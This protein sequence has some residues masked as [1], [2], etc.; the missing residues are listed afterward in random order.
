[1][2]K[3]TT[4]LVAIAKPLF[5]FI[6]VLLSLVFAKGTRKQSFFAQSF[7]KPIKSLIFEPTFDMTLFHMNMYIK[8]IKHWPPP[9]PFYLYLA[10]TSQ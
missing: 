6:L 2:F 9:V 8:Q 10:D 3:I 7:N 5:F 1:M 4:W